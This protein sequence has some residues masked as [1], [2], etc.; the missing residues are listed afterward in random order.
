[1]CIMLKCLQGQYN[2]IHVMRSLSIILKNV[3]D[4]QLDLI[5]IYYEKFNVNFVDFDISH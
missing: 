2:I 1:M 3:S 5:F 4:I